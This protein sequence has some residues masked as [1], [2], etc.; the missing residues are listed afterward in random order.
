MIDRKAPEEIQHAVAKGG[1]I[2]VATLRRLLEL[3]PQK[4]EYLFW[5]ALEVNTGAM[6][7]T[8]DNEDD[9]QETIRRLEGAPDLA[10]PGPSY[11]S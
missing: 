2:R 8:L 4:T 3:L 10:E 1:R 7:K 9:A 5:I 11:P 6:L